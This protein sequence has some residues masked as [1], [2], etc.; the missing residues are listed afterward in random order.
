MI[1]LT[2]IF[3]K[4]HLIYWSAKCL[5]HFIGTYLKLLPKFLSRYL[6][7]RNI[8]ET[9]T[10]KEFEKLQEKKGERNWHD[11]IL[12]EFSVEVEN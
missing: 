5:W 2:A 7:M 11:A 10:D 8:S 3:E 12:E 1:I 4:L 6:A 9:F